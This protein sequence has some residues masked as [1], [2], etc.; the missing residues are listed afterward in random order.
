VSKPL[1]RAIGAAALGYVFGTFPSADV[2]TRL[3]TGGTVDLRAAGSGNPGATNAS[4]VLGHRWGYAVL[5]ADIAKGALACTAGRAVAGD[6]GTHVAGTASVVGHC[7]PVWNGFR[8]GKGVACGVGQCA[9]TFPAY[10]PIHLGVAALTAA[11]PWRRRALTATAVGSVAWVAGGVIWWRRGWGNLW[12]PPPTGT[13]PLAAAASSAVVLYK[14]TSSRSEG[15]PPN[16]PR[17]LPTVG[18]PRSPHRR[19]AKFG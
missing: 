19:L 1:T 15:L 2:A 13:L 12:G 3:A 16:G 14:F 17:G 5:A 6:A 8:G 10:F 7:F 18:P 4:A 9:I 11:G